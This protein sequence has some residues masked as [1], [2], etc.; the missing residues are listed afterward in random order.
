MPSPPPTARLPADRGPAAPG[1]TGGTARSTG[2]PADRCPPAPLV[3]AGELCLPPGTAPE[4]A[5]AVVGDV[6]VVGPDLTPAHRAAALALLL[7]HGHGV[8]VR[9]TAAWVWTGEPS[10]RPARAD[11]AVPPS[12]PPLPGPR[13][14][15]GRSAMA[16][17]RTR[18]S[19][20]TPWS[21]LA[22]V[23]VTHPA[24]TAAECARRLP[25]AVA[26]RCVLALRREARVDLDEVVGLLRAA[27]RARAP[28]PPGTAE[29][30]RLLATLDR[31]TRR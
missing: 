25:E 7:P 11:L 6:L 14:A 10:I 29:A 22:G 8:L 24:A 13:P 2:W 31:P 5:R 30:L 19:P 15:P 12:P 3:L 16:V 4:G 23:A 17:R 26:R 21:R 1:A 27:A 28:A 20:G 18:W 9:A